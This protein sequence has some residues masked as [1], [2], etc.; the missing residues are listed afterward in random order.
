M[1]THFDRHKKP[2]NKPVNVIEDHRIRL[3]A[4]EEKEKKLEQRRF[5][6]EIHL[7]VNGLVD[8]LPTPK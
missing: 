1:N 4:T 7:P 6:S 5:L 3:L 2:A 8:Q